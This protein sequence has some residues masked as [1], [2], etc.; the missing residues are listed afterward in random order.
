MLVSHGIP[1][2]IG[3]VS[4]QPPIQRHP[5]QVDAMENMVPS[6]ASGLRKR[7]GTQHGAKLTTSNWSE[8][9]V[10]TINRGTADARERYFVVVDQ[11]NLSVYNSFGAPRAVDFPAGKGYLTASFGPGALARD[12]FSG[13]TVADY[14]FLVNKAVPVVMQE[15]DSI[16]IIPTFY[17]VVK[18]AV[19]S[20]G[21]HIG[22]DGTDYSFD[23][24]SSAPSTLNIANALKT[25]INAG[26]GFT[27]TSQDNLLIITKTAGGDFTA[28]VTDSYGDTAL[29]GFKDTVERFEELPRKFITGPVIRVKAAPDNPDATYYV[30]WAKTEGTA[31]GVWN[32]A[33]QPNIATDI[34]PTTMPWKLVRNPDDSFTFAPATWGSRAV[35]DDDTNAAP[36]F[37]GRTI[38]DVF[39]FRNRLGLLS[40][41]N[42]IMSEVGD[43]FNFWRTTARTDLES[44]PIDASASTNQVTLL[45]YALPFEKSILLFS[46]QAQFQ[47]SSGD[48]LS[49]RTA[50]LDPTTKFA[51][52]RTCRPAALGKNVFF[53]T[54][55]GSA[56]AVREYF[57]DASAVTSDASDVTAHVPSYVPAGVFRMTVAPTEDQLIAQVLGERNVLYVY[58]SYWQND[59]K[60]QSAW[61]RWVFHPA[62]VIVSADVWDSKLMLVVSRA[63]GTYLDTLSLEDH[64]TAAFALPYPV[65]LDRVVPFGTAGVY[66]SVSRRTS[67]LLGYQ[68]PAGATV[69]VVLNTTGQVGQG[70]VARIDGPTQVSIPG[71]FAGQHAAIGIEYDGWFRLSEQFLKDPKG[72]PIANARL[73]LRDI[74]MEFSQTGYFEAKVT[75]TG[76]D[77]RTHVFTGRRLGL[78]ALRLGTVT[79]TSGTFRVPVAARS[80]E[81]NIEF[82]NATHLPSIF[83]SADWQ[84]NAATQG[85]RR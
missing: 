81:V 62:D 46:D 74:A 34:D 57:F 82:H 35:G 58:N 73:T 72:E 67:W 16:T 56:T 32:E 59:E 85:Q 2:L 27:C 79:L 17:V 15:A 42:V 30:T 71:N 53:P 66:D 1:S 43:Y 52:S 19:A 38:E 80:D 60:V 55:R 3:G 33:V 77:E 40:D 37:V 75:P 6:V 41:E 78:S 51:A 39:F 84:A 63:D 68:I 29:F 7:H 11:G 83:L 14:T 45:H 65:C 10:H 26:S 4:Q 23:S 61:H 64:P 20:T 44:D 18:L 50:R 28:S 8:A 22:L 47:L 31:D 70:L 12:V 76:R 13:T 36:S 21:Y 49:A 24:P 25:A 5:S 48:V 9:F 69:R 54:P